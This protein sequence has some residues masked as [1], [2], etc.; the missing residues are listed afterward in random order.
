MDVCWALNRSCHKGG[1]DVQGRSAL[2]DSRLL[3]IG[4]NLSRGSFFSTDICPL[5]VLQRG[6]AA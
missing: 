1:G 5:S 3:F 2:Q 4:Q 6:V